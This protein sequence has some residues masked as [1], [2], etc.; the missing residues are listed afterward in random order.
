MPDSAHAHRVQAS[1][2]GA[3]LP[4]ALAVWPD[5]GATLNPVLDSARAMAC[6]LTGRAAAQ[7]VA[8]AVQPKRG[9]TLNPSA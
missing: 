8:L 9:A 6:R 4:L 7:P 5:R 1:G 3:A 2:R